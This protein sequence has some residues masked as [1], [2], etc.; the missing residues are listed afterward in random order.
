L[1]VT[2]QPRPAESTMLV[3]VMQ[4]WDGGSPPPMRAC[5]SSSCPTV[6]ACPPEAVRVKQQVEFVQDIG[7]DLATIARTRMRKLKFFMMGD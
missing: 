3:R 5:P 4:N 7:L 1:P 2:M 6:P